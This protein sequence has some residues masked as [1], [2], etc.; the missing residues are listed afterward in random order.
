MQKAMKS[1][2]EWRRIWVHKTFNIEIQK[3]GPN[4]SDFC[5]IGFSQ[6]L[7]P[8]ALISKN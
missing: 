6:K 4:N 5:K 8:R 1:D 7:G 2:K 3:G